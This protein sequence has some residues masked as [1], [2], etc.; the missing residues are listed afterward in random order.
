MKELNDL[1]P[2]IDEANHISMSLDKKVKFSA[3]AVS[4]AARLL[5]RFRK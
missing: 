3:L 2:L 1:M 4:S 5:G